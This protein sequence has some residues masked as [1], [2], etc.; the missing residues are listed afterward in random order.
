MGPAALRSQVQREAGP[1]LVPGRQDRIIPAR[2]PSGQTALMTSF[3]ATYHQVSMGRL[4]L[5]SLLTCRRCGAWALG[6]R[7]LPGVGSLQGRRLGF[8]EGILGEVRRIGGVGL[9]PF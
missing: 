3:A 8:V 6:I 2:H 1:D 9:G 5:T 4:P 7:D